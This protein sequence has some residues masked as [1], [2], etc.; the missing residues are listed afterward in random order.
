MIVQVTPVLLVLD[1]EAVNCSVAPAASVSLGGV[2]L[3]AMG[4]D[5][6]TMAEAE[7]LG[8]PKVD[9]VRVTVCCDSKV[10]GAV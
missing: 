5:K 2:T 3:I 9:T 1:T 4:G 10:A 8:V 7:R 6:V